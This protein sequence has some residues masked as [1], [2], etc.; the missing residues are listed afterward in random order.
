MFGKNDGVFT[1]TWV[2]EDK[3]IFVWGFLICLEPQSKN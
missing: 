2:F 1:E 3:F